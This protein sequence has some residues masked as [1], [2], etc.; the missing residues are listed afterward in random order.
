MALPEKLEL[1]SNA[2]PK[3]ANGDRSPDWLVVCSPVRPL[4]TNQSVFAKSVFEIYILSE[5][6]SLKK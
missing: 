4:D 3:D 2:T 6:Y 5:H 1:N